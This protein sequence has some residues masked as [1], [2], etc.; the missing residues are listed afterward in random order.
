MDFF[1]LKYIMWEIDDVSEKGIVRKCA[2][3]HKKHDLMF[4]FKMR[5]RF[6]GD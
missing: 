4:N 5:V 1:T 3:L 6:Y 2:F